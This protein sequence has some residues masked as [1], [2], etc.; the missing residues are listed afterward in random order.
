MADEQGYASQVAP[1][2][3]PG[4]ALAGADAFGAGGA[5]AL[6]QEGAS[7]HAIQLRSYQLDRE[8]Q[9][10]SQSADFHNRFAQ[11]RLNLDG[12]QNDLKN[13]AAPGGAGHVQATGQVLDAQRQSLFSGIT[14]Q[15]VLQH[16]QEQWT[17]YST[18]T[19]KSAQ[20][21][22]EG[23]RV[24]KQF[25][26]TKSAI[27]T[28]SNRA[29]SSSNP[30]TWSQEIAA[31]HG[32]V[33]SLAIPPDDRAKLA[34]YADNTIAYNRADYLNRTD[35]ATGKALIDAGV[36]NQF[37]E[38]HQLEMLRREND[39]GI[40]R[41]QAKQNA[42]LQTQQQSFIVSQQAV[43]R[44][45]EEGGSTPID[46][47]AQGETQA[48]QL[49]VQAKA[50]GKPTGELDKLADD[51]HVA[52]VQQK[53]IAQTTGVPIAE[54]QQQAEAAQAHVRAAIAAGQPVSVEDGATAKA[55]TTRA[56]Q[57]TAQV[58]SDPMALAADHG[59]ALAPVDPAN[60][61]SYRAREQQQAVQQRTLGLSYGF[62][63]LT[64]DEAAPLAK[65]VAEG[66]KGRQQ[67]LGYLDGFSPMA[68]MEAARQIAPGDAAFQAEAQVVPAVRASVQAG[69]EATKANAGFWPSAHAK[70]P[71]EA[72]AGQTLQGMDAQTDFA[73]RAMNP[74]DIAGVKQTSKDWLA[75]LYSGQG[76]ADGHGLTP[77]DY[78]VARAVGLGGHTENGKIMG[79]VATWGPQA[80]AFVVPETMSAGDFAHAAL[81]A[82]IADDRAGHGPVNRDGSSFNL[83]NA[84]PTY[85]GG[86]SYRWETSGG[87]V[88]ARGGS[89]YI[90]KLGGN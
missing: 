57:L 40:A 64:K 69:R 63:P 20:D 2:A 56:A 24:G 12:V 33:S 79:G 25:T 30:D 4:P 45:G 46:Q 23:Q 59:L 67:V 10:A 55:L 32:L 77:H 38:P 62:S 70:D 28:A 60:P 90:T 78:N 34:R 76:R 49:S 54:V 16:A 41:L 8:Q 86:N 80:K 66:D 21:W 37:I 61:A 39:V 15:S 65:A 36:Y 43:L 26:D 11:A 88:K 58:Q 31:A 17:N 73:M 87:V 81:A 5:A 42:A 89:P 68:R 82:R 48:R 72:K 14:E 13:S 83:N 52:Q 6:E 84:T 47:L 85:I 22:A 1:Q 51:L 19:L 18:D 74:A 29:A 7:L 3:G 71:D 44:H 35:P 75:G 27:D 50:A 53:V 9:A